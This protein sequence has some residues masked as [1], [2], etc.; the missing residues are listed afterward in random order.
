M[1]NIFWRAIGEI[2]RKF[3]AIRNGMYENAGMIIRYEEMHFIAGKFKITIIAE[4]VI[5]DLQSAI[6]K[7]IEDENYELADQLTKRLN[8]IKNQND[9]DRTGSI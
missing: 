8:N 6:K 4:E 5:E 7:A 2:F 1:N 3:A 9:E